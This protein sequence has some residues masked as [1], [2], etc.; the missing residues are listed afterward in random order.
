MKKASLYLLL[1]LCCNV[2]VEAMKV[3]KKT[4]AKAAMITLE[5]PD[6]FVH[7]TKEEALLSKLVREKLKKNSESTSLTVKTT[8]QLDWDTIRPLL[9]ELLKMNA[10][11]TAQEKKTARA[12]L[13][14]RCIGDGQQSLTAL[15]QAA[16][17]CKI[18]DLIQILKECQ[19]R[20]PQDTQTQPLEEVRAQKSVQSQEA[21]KVICSV[22]TKQAAGLA[23]GRCSLQVYCSATCQKQDWKRHKP[24]C[25]QLCPVCEK[26]KPTM[27]CNG[28]TLPYCSD[29][30]G[31]AEEHTAL[32]PLR[33]TVR[34]NY[35]LARATSYED[36]FILAVTVGDGALFDALLGSGFITITDGI[37]SAPLALLEACKYNSVRMVQEL[38][39][40]R[41]SLAITNRVGHTPMHYASLHEDGEL[42]RY[43][44]S[45]NASCATPN[46]SKG[47]LPL[48]EACARGITQTVDL[49]LKAHP[50]LK[51]Y[52]TTEGYT[53]FLCA[54]EKGHFSLAKHLID[55]YNVDIATKTNLSRNALHFAANNGSVEFMSHLLDKGFDKN[56][57]T[58]GGET[59]LFMA[60]DGGHV[61]ATR[62]LLTLKVDT[63]IAAINKLDAFFMAC[64]KGHTAVVRLFHE[65]YG[66][67]IKTVKAWNRAS[68][69][70]WASALEHPELV[71]YLLACGA[72][73]DVKDNE[74]HTPFEL[75]QNSKNQAVI[76]AFGK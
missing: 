48:H 1:L 43:L 24:D 72:P 49:F 11:T 42:V 70:H 21:V 67:D 18:S 37:C 19:S 71:R 34:E 58:L 4:K 15:L 41:A 16:E 59:P 17:A 40:R 45:K 27:R 57:K 29:T 5:V 30:C 38:V 75:A 39:N 56:G 25:L 13:R 54:C 10:L 28:C 65:E 8:S 44:M 63:T 60:C 7:L 36:L 73:T 3:A 68:A 53:P 52:R 32:C 47:A 20:I 6:G 51:E 35:Y 76:D 66:V 14:E 50:E 46:T 2:P 55:T 69:L 33:I 9:K 31:A 64:Y 26:E 23:C 61:D 74:G 22:C 62:F 12:T